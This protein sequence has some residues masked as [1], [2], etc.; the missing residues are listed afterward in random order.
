MVERNGVYTNSVIRKL[1]FS[2]KGDDILIYPNPVTSSTIFISASANCK[3]ALLYDASGKLVKSFVLQGR[4]NT[5]N[6]IGIAKGIYQLKIISAN[7]AHTE[8]LLVQ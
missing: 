6:I 8:K 7:S 4:N 2:N 3:N 5:I 1:D